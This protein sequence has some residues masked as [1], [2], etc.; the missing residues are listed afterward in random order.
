[1]NEKIILLRDKL[2]KQIITDE[3][4]SKIYNTSVKLDEL[5][6]LYYKDININLDQ[7][8]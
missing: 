8:G 2:E 3:S 7:T 1:M 5:I 4:Y 6:I